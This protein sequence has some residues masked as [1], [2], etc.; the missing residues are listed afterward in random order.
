MKRILLLV[1]AVFCCISLSAQTCT[2][3]TSCS[4]TTSAQFLQQLA[5]GCNDINIGNNNIDLTG[6]IID[7][8]GVR[9]SYSGAASIALDGA[10]IVGDCSNFSGTSGSAE[11]VVSIAG[12]DFVFD[13]NTDPSIGDLNASI[14]N[15]ATTLGGAVLAFPVRLVSFEGTLKKDM[16]SLDWVS[17]EEDGNDY[18]TI[19]TSS[20]GRVFTFAGR[21]EGQ[22]YSTGYTS[23]EWEDKSPAAG[24]NHYR[25][26]QTD[27]D[28]TTSHLGVVSLN[29]NEA[30]WS[31]S[32]NP[33]MKN[34]VVN[35]SGIED[36]SPQTRVQLLNTNGE[37][38]TTLPISERLSLPTNLTTGI[39]LLRVPG[40]QLSPLRIV[41]R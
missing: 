17:A 10:T 12:T 21:I 25:L 40:K 32:P 31:V 18:Y 39:Y 4:V 26:L 33:V 20:D 19:E 36:L 22:G 5:A 1:T 11:I 3:G 30:G 29:W 14:V 24:A 15:G 35:L 2:Y 27:L 37:I 41:I 8:S 28:G 7:L 6:E 34:G 9:I 16:I 13:K 23:Y 38:I